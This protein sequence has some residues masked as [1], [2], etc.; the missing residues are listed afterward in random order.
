MALEHYLIISVVCLILTNVLRYSFST[1]QNTRGHRNRNYTHQAILRNCLKHNIYLDIHRR[2]EERKKV[3]ERR[4]DR[5]GQIGELK[6]V[7]SEAS[8]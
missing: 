7:C 3:H 2:Q 4:E 5:P 6:L 8:F 1:F